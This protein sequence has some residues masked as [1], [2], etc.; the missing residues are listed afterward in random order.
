MGC[1]ASNEPR[2]SEVRKFTFTSNGKRYGICLGALGDRIHDPYRCNGGGVE[3]EYGQA[4]QL[5][6]CSPEK[7]TTLF[8]SQQYPH[9]NKLLIND[10]RR[11]C[12]NVHWW[13]LVEGTAC[14]IYDAYPTGPATGQ[15]WIINSDGSISQHEKRHLVLGLANHH[16]GWD[17]VKLVKAGAPS[18]ILLDS[19]TKQQTMT[20]TVPP[21]AAPGAHL[22]ITAPSGQPIDIVV[23]PGAG[24]G[25]QLRVPVPAT[26]ATAAPAGR[27]L[28]GLKIESVAQTE[29]TLAWEQG[30]AQSFEVQ[31]RKTWGAWH[32]FAT[33]RRSKARVS[34][35]EAGAWYAFRVRPWS[36]E[37]AHGRAVG[38][39][40]SYE[41]SAQLSAPAPPADD[42]TQNSRNKLPGYW[43]PIMNRLNAEKF[44]VDPGSEEYTR[45]EKAFMLTLDDPSR[46][47][48]RTQFT[49]QSV[50]RIQNMDL[51][52]LYVAKR[53]SIC[54]RKSPKDAQ[55]LV[56]NWL[57]HGGR[58]DT[59]DKILQ[60]G[61]NRSFAGR[62]ATLY[63]KGVYFARDASYSTY[64]R[65]SQRDANDV[66]SIFLARVVVGEYCLGVQ[67]AITPDVRD[68]ATS[69]LYDSTVDNV[70]DP[71]IFV[72]YNDGQAYPEYLV[73][74]KQDGNP[75]S[76]PATGKP[77]LPDYRPNVFDDC[78]D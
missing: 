55:S 78:Y 13:K 9:V 17:V 2:A 37:S 1:C 56:R 44:P 25:T 7:A 11:R 42:T 15:K 62:N 27:T 64:P 52:N 26:G 66:Q 14:S 51:W 54:G 35:L 12:I 69:A 16:S 30:S 50:E 68:A 67:D 24:P 31:W 22:R 76:H 74:F 40:W 70:R 58:P 19:P 43:N 46:N 4:N 60:Q 6:V 28:R 49:I 53:K 75:P 3:G 36:Y 41:V 72:T 57:F 59:V 23:P 34:G 47:L 48:K 71:S 32:N 29:V 8:W 39:E 77:A 10:Q 73:K 38:G 45:V 20:I 5:V 21:G 18:A 33:V 65:Y 61:F 63:G